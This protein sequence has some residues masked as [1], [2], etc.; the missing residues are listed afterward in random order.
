ML[1]Y[2]GLLYLLPQHANRTQCQFSRT[3]L[4]TLQNKD[5]SSQ[6]DLKCQ[7]VHPNFAKYTGLGPINYGLINHNFWKHN[8]LNLYNH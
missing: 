2:S 4:R 1:N 5:Q 7:A 8:W 6:A 3:A